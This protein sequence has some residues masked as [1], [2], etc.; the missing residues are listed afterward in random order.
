MGRIARA[1]A[2]LK[3]GAFTLE[4]ARAAGISPSALRGK[5][6]R[7]LGTGIYC[8]AGVAADPWSLLVA[9]QSRLPPCAAFAGFTAA[10]LHGLDV[11][12]CHPVEILVPATY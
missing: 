3:H 9:W 10:W 11:D 7:R 8:W 1:P 2:D 6:W 4:Q 5:S 12:P